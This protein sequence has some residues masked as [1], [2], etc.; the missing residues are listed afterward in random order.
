[1]ADFIQQAQAV[2]KTP[3]RGEFISPETNAQVAEQ[4]AMGATG[5]PPAPQGMPAGAGM[6]AVQENPITA[7]EEAASPEEQQQYTDLFNR[8]MAM[9]NDTRE[10]NGEKS[11]AQSVV[12]LLGTKD[13]PAHQAIGT[14]AGMVMT[15]MVTLAK[16]N[17]QEYAGPVIQEV[18]MDLVLELIDI[19]KGSGA[20][21]NIPEEDSEPFVKLVELSVLEAA[22]FYG[23]HQLRTGQADQQGHM[24]EIEE[25][26]QR[27]AD[28][29]EL[30]DWGMEELDPAMRERIAGSLR[31]AQV[32]GGAPPQ[33]GQ[34]MPQ[35]GM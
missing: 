32:Q 9:V 28:A 13:K 27:E 10:A 35:G 16:R 20:I 25:Q 8:V 19:A 4:A 24:R 29:G 15:H 14:T 3:G 2:E 31:P 17:G 30:D 11:V 33:G 1:M 5:Q 18:G 23:E 21:N 34:Q 22:K 7:P 26:M 6:G 12:E